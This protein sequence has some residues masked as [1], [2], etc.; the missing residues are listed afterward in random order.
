MDLIGDAQR[1]GGGEDAAAG[2][3]AH[4]GSV[5]LPTDSVWEEMCAEDHPLN[6][7][8]GLDELDEE[9]GFDLEACLAAAAVLANPAEDAVPEGWPEELARLLER[10]ALTRRLDE[11]VRAVEDSP[12]VLGM[13]VEIAESFR[14]GMLEPPGAASSVPDMPPDTPQE[15]LGQL[16]GLGRLRVMLGAIEDRLMLEAESRIIADR[17]HADAGSAVADLALARRTSREKTSRDLAAA[18]RTARHLPRLLRAK[19]A[20][21]LPEASASAIASTL[22]T[23]SAATCALV[24]EVLSTDDYAS[25]EGTGAVRVR[26]RV[27]EIIEE[28]TS[29]SAS[30]DRAIAAARGRYVKLTPIRDGMARIT[31][32]LPAVHGAQIHQT[33]QAVAESMRA[34]G[35][36]IPIGAAR[37]DALV[38]AVNMFCDLATCRIDP[39]HD[40]FLRA[41]VHGIVDEDGLT[42]RPVIPPSVG[43]GLVPPPPPHVMSEDQARARY[44]P[45][46]PGAEFVDPDEP[47][48]VPELPARARRELDAM[49][50]RLHGDG[51]AQAETTLAAVRAAHQDAPI[52][53]FG[54]LGAARGPDPLG[55]PPRLD[56]PRARAQGPRVMVTLIMNVTS[57]LAP[58]DGNE[59]ASLSG[60]GT[61][62]AHHLSRMLTGEDSRLPDPGSAQEAGR[63]GAD[64]IATA[65]LRRAFT[66]PASGEIQAV[67]STSRAFPAAVRDLALARQA[68]SAAPYSNATANQVD[69]I[70]RA[71]DGGPS[72]LANAQALDAAAN[73]TKETGGWTTS[74]T[75]DPTTPTGSSV[76]WRNA[77]GLSVRI[78]APRHHPPRPGRGAAPGG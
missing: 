19:A 47:L 16:A 30:I 60:Y 73:Y 65:Q 1:A 41:A 75:G 13:L 35:S 4:A 7:V 39:E 17:G 59:L 72:T 67:E 18:R 45:D 64:A 11:V 21:R 38:E 56:P 23:E 25:I 20:G 5:V 48:P 69:H 33:V 27:R 43:S 62:P 8:G 37:A 74:V 2:P 53:A 3:L 51:R 9:D 55:P 76:E 50:A 34:A 57:L 61:L 78:A 36:R 32:V 44:G 54:P 66:H 52:G 12:Q 15:A 14:T 46:E 68:I 70:R 31:A 6:R 58:E 42:D 40:G 77:Y 63:R 26:A 22:G 49:V 10:Q 71:A 28:N 29:R 24:D